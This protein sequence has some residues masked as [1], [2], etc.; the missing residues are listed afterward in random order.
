MTEGEERIKALDRYSYG[1]VLNSNDIKSKHIFINLTITF[2]NIKMFI[3]Q[4]L[5]LK[6]K[7][8]LDPHDFKTLFVTALQLHYSN[9]KDKNDNNNNCSI[10]TC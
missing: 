3:F 4:P 1:T 5:L 7:N 2:V 8:I 9:Y 6:N 10:F